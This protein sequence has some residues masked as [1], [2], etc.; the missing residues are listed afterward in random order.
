MSDVADLYILVIDDNPEIHKDLIKILTK[1]PMEIAALDALE[2]QIFGG[3]Y[4]N[5][6]TDLP[7][8]VIDTAT[9]GEEG[10]MRVE[11]A[12]TNGKKYALAFV[13]IR[14]PPGLDGVETIRRLWEIDPDIQAVI[15]T[16]YSDYTWEETIAALGQKENL[17]ILKKPFDGIAVRQLACAL[18]KKWQLVNDAKQYTHNLKQQIALRTASLE[19]S[20]SLVKATL[21]SSN[22]GILVVNNEHAIVDFNQ[23]F[24]KMWSIPRT[25]AETKNEGALRQFMFNQLSEPTELFTDVTHL[26]LNPSN[27][28]DDCLH[29]RDGKI[30]EYYTQAQIVKD[31]TVGLVFN[32]RDITER[33]KLERKL[34]YQASHDALTG[35]PNRVILLEKIQQAAKVAQQTNHFVAILFL[36]LDRF[37]LINDSLTHAAGDELLKVTAQRLQSIMRSQDTLIRLGGDEFIIILTDIAKQE[38]ILNKVQK[39]RSVFQEPFHIGKRNVLV[40]ASIGIS[41]FPR[42]G[43]NPDIL[44]RNAD[45]AMYQAKAQHG[46]TYQFYTEEL[47]QQSV[48]KLDHEMRL[49]AA[50]ENNELFL[51]YQPQIDSKT[52]RIIAAEALI[53]WHYSEDTVLLPLDF[54]PLAEETGLIVSIGEWVL[55]QACAQNK[56]WQNAGLPHFRIAVNVTA[57]QFEHQ[58]MVKLVKDVLRETDLNPKYLELE[59]TE[60]AVISNAKV[61]EAVS[62]LKSFG[63][64]IAID[65][66]GTGYSSLSYLRKIP[67]NRL[68]IDRSFIQNV[69][70]A[71]DDEVIIRA[72]IA[73]AK[74]LNLDVIAEGVETQYQLNFLKS[75]D[76][77][78]VQG[79]YFSKPLSSLEL[80]EYLERTKQ[81]MEEV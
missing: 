12:L 13:D 66:F 17:L 56:A 20:L 25:L 8:F 65:D 71:T 16:A 4:K 15:C 35:L 61:I 18:T 28:V 41:V 73:M 50:L 33:A 43:N 63:V 53:R 67:L 45:A 26:K 74:N 42:D 23:T 70:S 44:L 6:I 57:Q 59:L 40:T 7:H 34:E 19:E 46:N 52:G 49:R 54:I 21:E 76:C 27:N 69:Q 31:Q 24:L 80:A 2:T 51:Y 29:L 22:E 5:Q 1:K 11:E 36:D 14:M 30:F 79:Y 60:N 81:V 77:C 3:E 39:I 10:I 37:K 64:S 32:F 47:N 72:V 9:Q 75:H 62:E 48:E 38:H 55:R 68:K 78:D 58:N